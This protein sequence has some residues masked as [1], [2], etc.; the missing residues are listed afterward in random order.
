MTIYTI[1]VT[2]VSQQLY[3]L[4]RRI[5]Q[6]FGSVLKSFAVYLDSETDFTTLCCLV[7]CFQKSQSYPISYFTDETEDEDANKEYVE[8]T[9]RDMVMVA[10]AKLVANDT[11]PKVKSTIADIEV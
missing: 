5:L 3:L 8:E 11:V 1:E 2:F 4:P 9:S 7:L 10:A 6:I